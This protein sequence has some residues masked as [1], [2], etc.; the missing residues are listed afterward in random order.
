MLGDGS[1]LKK[2]CEEVNKTVP[3]FYEWPL[4]QAFVHK[5]RSY[6]TIDDYLEY[7]L[8][9]LSRTSFNFSD[10]TIRK[11]SNV[12]ALPDGAYTILKANPKSLE[13]EFKV[14]DN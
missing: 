2:P 13:Y 9:V 4:F 1:V 5:N 8:D 3:Y 10:R 12:D 14:N 6:R 11:N 7:H